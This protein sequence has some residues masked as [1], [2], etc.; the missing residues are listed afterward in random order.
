MRSLSKPPTLTNWID[1]SSPASYVD[2]PAEIR[3][4]QSGWDSGR[5]HPEWIAGIRA[6]G[7]ASQIRA[8]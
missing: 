6:V 5:A 4:K 7:L 1:G 8:L 3:R 2:P